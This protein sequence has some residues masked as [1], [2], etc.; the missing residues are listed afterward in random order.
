MPIFE[1]DPWRLQYFSN[2]PCPNDVN[3]PTE[4]SDAWV[5]NPRHRWVYDRIAIATSQGIAAGPHGTIPGAFPVFSKPIVNLKGMGLGAR[6]VSSKDEY[7]RHHMPGHMWMTLLRGTHLSSDV[8]VVSGIPLWWCHA[9]GLPADGGTFDYWIVGAEPKPGL[10]QRLDNW[11]QM[12]LD[13]YT[14]MVNLET[15]GGTIIE[16]HLRLTD[17]WP[18]LYGQDW[19][20][21]VVGLYE[22][23]HWD[24]VDHRGRRGYSVALFGPSGRQYRHPPR[25]LV[26]E[27]AA[28]RGISSVQITFHED[29]DPQH[30]AM[31]SGGFRL[32]VINCRELHVG[33]AAR[34]QLKAHFHSGIG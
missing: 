34:E 19:V 31:P 7:D 14:G 13:G 4:D 26:D 1:I 6:V 24:F 15:I 16:V 28:T 8:A 10:E 33:I 12:H 17:Q 25:E 11:V 3:I 30:H 23:G 29:R 21:S 27:L 18:D 20:R 32:A 2:V 5:W 22:R 9:V